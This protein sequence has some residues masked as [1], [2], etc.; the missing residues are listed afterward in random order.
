MG[1]KSNLTSKFPRLTRISVWALAITL[2]G[3][4]IAV[5]LRGLPLVLAKIAL[6]SSE[7][8]VEINSGEL[9]LVGDGIFPRSERILVAGS[10]SLG[11][12]VI[13]ASRQG[14]ELG[15]FDLSKRQIEKR[16][17]FDELRITQL[18]GIGGGLEL[19]VFDLEMGKDEL[20]VSLVATDR[21]IGTC[22]VYAVIRI[23]V[24]NQTNLGTAS[25]LWR[26][27]VCRSVVTDSYLWPDFTGRLAFDGDILYMTSGISSVDLVK[28]IF[29]ATQIAG[30]ERSL[31][32]EME[33]NALAGR[34]TAISTID[35]SS[36]EFAK[37][38]RSPA[39]IAIRRLNSGQEIWVSDHGPRGGDELNLISEGM[40]YGFPWVSLGSSY[41]EAQGANVPT[42]FLNHKGFEP[43]VFSWTP[44]IAPSQI[45]AL[46]DESF[47]DVGWL[48][49]DLVLGTLK[50]QSIVYIALTSESKVLHVESVSVGH[51]VRDMTMVEGTIV[52]TTDDGM[53]IQVRPPPAAEKPKGTFPLIN[54]P[55][56]E[57][58]PP[59]SFFVTAADWLISQIGNVVRGSGYLN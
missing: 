28:E 49:H 38:L 14:H 55:G 2:M 5:G 10:K 47:E 51:R 13:V 57:S 35:G 26:S 12:N 37:G 4:I 25:E 45:L 43:P 17:S 19:H 34:I 58:V 50:A 42:I 44:S 53:L 36:K 20:F 33:T 1:A 23:P 16:F 8:S 39:G 21:T 18:P 56:F 24:E 15:F 27:E 29:P 31:K 41:G 59:F 22:D 52:L 11:G 7:V 6:P 40:D 48:K 46:T 3:L 30:I 9:L 54:P 32:L